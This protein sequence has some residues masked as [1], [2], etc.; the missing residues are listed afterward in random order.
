[1]SFM[2]HILFSILVAW[3]LWTKSFIGLRGEPS[4]WEPTE[5]FQTQQQC[6]QSSDKIIEET[7]Q[8]ERKTNYP[9]EV[10]RW[11]NSVKVQ[12]QGGLIFHWFFYCYPDTFDPR[13][14]Q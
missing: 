14:K 9:T 8:S 2:R 6:R 1:M 11:R 5:A 3:V 12:K 13:P 7:F 10:T 4:S